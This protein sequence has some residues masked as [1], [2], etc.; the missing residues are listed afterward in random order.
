MVVAADVF[1]GVFPNPEECEAEIIEVFEPAPYCRIPYD[2]PLRGARFF[3]MFDITT[4]LPGRM[5][6]LEKRRVGYRFGTKI[7]T[8]VGWADYRE[9]S[10]Q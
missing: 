4:L 9:T 8:V 6:Y 10:I 3:E 2:G 1:P 7:H 5:L